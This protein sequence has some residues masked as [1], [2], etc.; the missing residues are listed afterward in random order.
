MKNANV[1]SKYLFGKQRGGSM[2]A[3]HKS[4]L[5]ALRLFSKYAGCLTFHC[6]ALWA[7]LLE[8]RAGRFQ[9]KKFRIVQFV[10][11]QLL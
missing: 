3:I 9:K 10:Q 5:L 1:K 11:P 2:Q 4:L 6:G 7:K 8:V